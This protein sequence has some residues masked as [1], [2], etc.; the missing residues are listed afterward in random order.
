MY[1]QQTNKPEVFFFPWK[2]VGV[3]NLMKNLIK[4]FKSW[5]L[6]KT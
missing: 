5:I 6:D 2:H 4:I 1:I 3:L